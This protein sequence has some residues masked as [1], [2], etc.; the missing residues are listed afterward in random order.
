LLPK[1][2][3]LFAIS[4]H[5]KAGLKELINEIYKTVQTEKARRLAEAPSAEDSLPVVTISDEASWQIVKIAKGYRVTGHKIERFA[6]RTDF[7]NY[8]GVQ[9]LRDIMRKM[10]I[11]HELKRKKI[12]PG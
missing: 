2:T 4:S 8:H 6:G 10:G 1:N 3:K 9:R 7:E 11:M 5:S 12:N